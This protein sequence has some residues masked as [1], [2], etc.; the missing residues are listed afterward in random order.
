MDFKTALREKGILLL[1]GAMG[2]RLMA[3]GLPAGTPPEAWNVENPDAVARV[4][5]EYVDAGAD[6]VLTNTF[7]A[8]R[9]KM[10]ASGMEEKTLT[11]VREA[12]RIA[13]GI[14]EGVIVLGDIGP[15]GQLPPSLGGKR[16]EMEDAFREQA[17]ILA[18]EGVDGWIVETMM[19]AE[20]CEIAVSACRKV[21][22][23]PL[24]AMLSFDSYG[25]GVFHTMMGD[26]Q[27]A[28]GRLTD[29]GA[30]MIGTN[31]GSLDA[32]ELCGLVEFLKSSKRFEGIPVVV[33]PNAG[34]PVLEGGRTVYPYPPEAMEEGIRCLV[35][36]GVDVLGGCCGTTPDH[37][38]LMKEVVDSKRK[39]D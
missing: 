10:K 7:G 14:G 38:A 33:E 16:W 5:R 35:D 3:L 19:S 27:D 4:H 36:A 32:G 30:D 15:T 6:I 9:L 12:V 2:T 11:V 37:I 26:D 25:D 8:N 13:K 20:E 28:F 31:C 39:G 22:D 24:V 21:G 29:A 18:E 1:D 34:K 17:E 23:L